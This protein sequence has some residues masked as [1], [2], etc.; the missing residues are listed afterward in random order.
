[1]TIRAAEE[2]KVKLVAEDH[3]AE[4]G[5]FYR[6]FFGQMTGAALGEPK[7]PHL[8]MTQPAGLPLLH[9]CHGYNRIFF[10]DF[11]K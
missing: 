2:F 5:Y 1:M 3:G 8:V 6:N 9:L 11:K 10:A 7:R 4:I